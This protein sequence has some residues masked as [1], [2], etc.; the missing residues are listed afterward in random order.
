VKI[1]QDEPRLLSLFNHYFLLVIFLYCA[2]VLKRKCKACILP[3]SWTGISNRL[4]DK[5]TVSFKELDSN[6]KKVQEEQDEG[7]G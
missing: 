4:Q 5:S 3:S 6:G 7:K 2:K 1:R